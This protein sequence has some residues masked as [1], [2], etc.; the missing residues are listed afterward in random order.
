MLRFKFGQRCCQK[1]KNP[2]PY[3]GNVV[4]G[5]EIKLLVK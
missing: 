5:K 1:D 3:R 4:L 2:A